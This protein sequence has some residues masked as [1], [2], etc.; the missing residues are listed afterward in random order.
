[1]HI[2]RHVYIYIY[3]YTSLGF[4]APMAMKAETVLLSIVTY[5]RDGYRVALSDE[6]PFKYYTAIM[7]HPFH[8]VDPCTSAGTTTLS[9]KHSPPR[10][11]HQPQPQ[12]PAPPPPTYSHATTEPSTSASSSLS[13]GPFVKTWIH[14]ESKSCAR[15]AGLDTIY[16]YPATRHHQMK[17]RRHR[18]RSYK[19]KRGRSTSPD[20][21]L[22]DHMSIFHHS[23]PHAHAHVLPSMHA[24]PSHLPRPSQDHENIVMKHTLNPTLPYPLAD[25]SICQENH[26]TLAAPDLPT[27][28]PLAGSLPPHECTSMLYFYIY[29]G[30]RDFVI[31]LETRL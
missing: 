20:S 23:S 25:L 1:M 2:V 5:T 14:K 18:R 16:D 29:H 26:E 6:R 9:P 7:N 27:T 11:H 8:H 30:G 15:K 4:L 17:T 13:C 22:N 10:H 31:S 28:H 21:K 3:I 19:L 24:R 12:Y